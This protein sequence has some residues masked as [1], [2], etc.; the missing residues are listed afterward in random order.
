M[1]VKSEC[2]CEFRFIETKQS[3]EQ[4]GL[5]RT[6]NF[7]GFPRNDFQLILIT[8]HLPL[9]GS[10]VGLHHLFLRKQYPVL[11]ARGNEKEEKS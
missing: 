8:L 6:S 5:L 9:S 1:P 7:C 4:K 11:D 3:A 10:T 2:H